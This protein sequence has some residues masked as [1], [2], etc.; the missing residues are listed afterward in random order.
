[1][2][3]EMSFVKDVLQVRSLIKAS[4]ILSQ[5]VGVAAVK[6]EIWLQITLLVSFS[7]KV[8]FSASEAQIQKE[9]NATLTSVVAFLGFVPVFVSRALLPFLAEAYPQAASFPADIFVFLVCASAW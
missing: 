6:G 9:N 4:I 8:T 3:T 1:M 2:D 5:R 7:Y